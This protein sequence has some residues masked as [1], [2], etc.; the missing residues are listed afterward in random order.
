MARRHKQENRVEQDAH[1]SSWAVS[2]MKQTSSSSA[3]PSRKASNGWQTIVAIVFICLAL[4]LL[5]LSGLLLFNWSAQKSYRSAA[6]QLQKNISAAQS[7]S[8]KVED[9]RSSQQQVTAM[10]DDL[11]SSRSAQVR[12]L[13]HAVT[14]ASNTSRK[15]DRILDHM[16]RG[17]DWDSARKA[18]SRPKKAPS[19]PQKKT[20]PHSSPARMPSQQRDQAQKQQ[21]EEQKKKLDRLVSRTQSSTNSTLKPW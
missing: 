2:L 1:S 20:R 14:T 19:S 8:K 12:P 10:L 16:S 6:Q 4:V 15:L 17:S 3:R 5:V 13:A 9:I 21:E 7:G 11:L 18:A